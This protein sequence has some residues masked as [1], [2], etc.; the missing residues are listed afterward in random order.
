MK[1][2]PSRIGIRDV[3]SKA[4]LSVATVSRTLNGVGF[5]KQETR[6]RVM[7]AVAE[8]NYIPDPH[9]RSLTTR[10]SRRSSSMTS[11]M[12]RSSTRIAGP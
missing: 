5:V 7:R 10:R 8:L 11:A 9:A 4:G 1:D 2:A 3:A 12:V 6:E